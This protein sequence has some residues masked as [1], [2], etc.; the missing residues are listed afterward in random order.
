[1]KHIVSFSGV[2]EWVYDGGGIWR[3]KTY[4]YSKERE[5]VR[6]KW[7]YYKKTRCSICGNPHLQKKGNEQKYNRSYCSDKCRA[8]S[9]KVH[10]QRE[11]HMS[12]KNGKYK[13]QSG[14]I[15]INKP[16][17][18]RAVKGYV[19]EHIVIAEKKIGRK[20][21]RSEDVHHINGVRDD[22]RYE[23]LEV[24]TRSAHT[25]IHKNKKYNITRI[26]LENEI[27]ENNKTFSELAREI[28]CS[29]GLVGLYCKEYGIKS[30][31]RKK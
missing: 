6:V 25:K 26:L 23:N 19:Y 24:L 3:N 2:G 22:N 8:D 14:Y 9:I 27:V 5:K 18:H 4:Y 21:T 17:H 11:N 16:E 31:Y 1:M 15:C 29:A 10:Y 7:I 28:G 20:I 30:P 12:Y 13:T